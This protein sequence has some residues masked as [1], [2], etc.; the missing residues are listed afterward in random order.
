[1]SSASQQKPHLQHTT[2][3]YTSGV[4]FSSQMPFVQLRC[5]HPAPFRGSENKDRH[6]ELKNHKN[7]SGTGFLA[8][9]HSDKLHVQISVC[10]PK[11]IR[12]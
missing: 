1:M 9:T 4:W 7:L 11:H 8:R 2:F 12:I 6:E 5:P 3:M 10:A